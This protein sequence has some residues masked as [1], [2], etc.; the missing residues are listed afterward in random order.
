M[1]SALNMNMYNENLLPGSNIWNGNWKTAQTLINK[2]APNGTYMGFVV[3]ERTGTYNG[4]YQNVSVEANK[5]YTFE[6]FVKVS[7]A[8]N[9]SVVVGNSNSGDGTTAT[10]NVKSKAFPVPANQWTHMLLTFECSV[11]GII[12]PRIENTT[13]ATMS[14]CGYV[15]YEGYP[16][17]RVG[18][19]IANYPSLMKTTEEFNDMVY[20]RVNMLENELIT[21]GKTYNRGTVTPQDNTGGKI[22]SNLIPVTEGTTYYF[23]NLWAYFSAVRYFD[24]TIVSLSDATTTLASGT[25][26]AAKNGELAITLGQTRTNDNILL[27]T[28]QTLY[29]S[30][31]YATEYVPNKLKVPKVYHVE[32]DGSGDFTKL[33]DAITEAEKYMDST[34]YVGKGTWDVIEEMGDDFENISVNNRGLYLKNRIHLIFAS[35]SEWVCN[36]TGTTASVIAWACIFNSGVYGFTLENATLKGSNIRYL[37]HD[38][39]DSDADSYINRY[40]NCR[41]EL[42]NSQ[43]TSA[44]H[45]CIGGG[46]GL[47]GYVEI[48][49]CY[50]KSVIDTA[51][52]V[53]FYHN[54]AAADGGAKSHI[55][56]KNCY[57]DGLGRFGFHWYGNSQLITEVEVSGCS[58][59]AELNIGP[60]TQ[61]A[62]YENV[63]VTEWNNIVRI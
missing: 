42:D 43:S 50:F 54:S 58:Y 57:A 6:A 22:I 44:T 9:V 27:T 4:L 52:N 46:L 8:Q 28:N 1:A 29:N 62:P 12:A 15:L 3:M 45:Q 38:E 49:G 26:T 30:G 55:S 7:S 35:D 17:T 40:I 14:V 19:M 25:F 53:M 41:F 10:T 32:K 23:R 56:V 59:G 24:G 33:I 5:K 20:P 21:A 61:T 51:R 48:D 34:V 13:R 2:W 18:E 47:C 63:H 11:S 37:V 60:E 16:V 39:R 36:Y 31:T